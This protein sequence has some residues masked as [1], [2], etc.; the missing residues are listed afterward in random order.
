GSPHR[1]PRARFHAGSAHSQRRVVDFP[2]ETR[3]PPCRVVVSRA[4]S[5]TRRRE[6][7]FL[8]WERVLLVPG[9][10]ILARERVSACRG[11]RP[12]DATVPDQPREASL[13]RLGPR[14]GGS[15]LLA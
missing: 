12:G 8:A 2:L 3:T 9:C 14:D 7:E 5:R 4:K 11:S 1:A 13:T 6:Y 15:S 10:P